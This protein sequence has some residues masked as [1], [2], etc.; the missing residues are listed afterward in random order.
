VRTEKSWLTKS[1]V[2]ITVNAEITET[3]RMANVWSE[4]GSQFLLVYFCHA[5]K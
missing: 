4:A 2:Y 3:V 1:L 5:G